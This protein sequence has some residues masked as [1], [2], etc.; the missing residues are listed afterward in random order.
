MK[1]L[2]FSDF[3]GLYGLV[4]HFRNV[5]RRLFEHQP[6]LL[7]FCG[8]FRNSIPLPLL[9]SRLRRLKFAQIYYVWGNSDDLKPTFELRTGINLHLKI[10]QL[11]EEF[12]IAGIGGDELD[13]EW[14]VQEFDRQL[15]QI[16]TQ[17]LILISH[18]PP[19]GQL[20]FA[21]EEKHVG[22]KPYQKLIEK[23]KPTLCLFGHIHEQASK[24]AQ[25]DSISY[26]NV[27]PKGAVINL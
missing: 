12:S 17:K 8:D 7:I 18:V 3:H 25:F 15:E 24:S 6:D 27:G 20:D 16:K 23:Y 22:S 26:W 1:I 11:N 21:I 9:E 13:V 2:A 14:N 10:I 5:K 4:N 19:F